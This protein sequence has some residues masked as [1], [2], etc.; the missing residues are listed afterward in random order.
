M[1]LTSRLK[2]L[3]K[4]K[5]QTPQPT[6]SPGPIQV[7]QPSRVVTPN[8]TLALA[9]TALTDPM[10]T[11]LLDPGIQQQLQA[12]TQ[13]AIPLHAEAHSPG[14][15]IAKATAVNALKLFLGILSDVPGPGVKIAL[16]GLLKIIE[17]VQVCCRT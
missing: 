5:T 10:T 15:S 16:N 2:K 13:D 17:K 3:F 6:H 1:K 8:P 14:H 11:E 4:S 9:G 7:Q 12:Q